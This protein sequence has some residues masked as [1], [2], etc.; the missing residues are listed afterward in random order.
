MSDLRADPH[1]EYEENGM[2]TGIYVRALRNDQWQ[3]VDLADLDRA[4]VIQF[5]E[6]RGPVTTWARDIIL[7]ML[8]HD[9]E[10]LDAPIAQAANPG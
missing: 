2:T 6:S 9:R 8:G 5:V 3:N 7:I 10:G 4:S 1:R